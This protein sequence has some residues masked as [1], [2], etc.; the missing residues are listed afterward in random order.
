MTAHPLTFGVLTAAVIIGEMMPLKVSRRG[1]D[2]EITMSSSF[3][4]A[5]L[6]A[7]GLGPAVI[8]QC[9]ASIAQDVTGR[10]PGWR[11]RFNIGQYTMSMVAAY[12]VLRLFSVVPI[13]SAHPYTSMQL[14][15]ILSGATVFF[16]AN[17]VLVGIAFALYQGVPIRRYLREDPAFVL[18]SG[19]V[20]LLLVPVVLAAAAFSVM[21][22]PL[23]LAPMVAIYNAMARGARSE[24]AARH[25]ALTG[26]P[27][28]TAFNDAVRDM[29]AVEDVSGCVLLIDLDRFKDVNDTL[30]HRFGDLLLGQVAER[31][32][33]SCA[34]ATRS[35][36]W[37]ATSSRSCAPGAE[38]KR[39]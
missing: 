8:A 37:A 4:M 22:V 19:V 24:H 35:P 14:P 3:A 32:Q 21:L 23:C 31:F 30:G 18:V 5:L 33:R 29:M 9:V 11:I 10:K 38:A 36:G 13:G 28:R 39:R 20:M 12:L 7:G 34:R 1:S 15:G 2:E 27:N 17:T 25:D 26:L 6:L 16:L